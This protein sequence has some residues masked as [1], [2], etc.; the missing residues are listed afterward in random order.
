MNDFTDAGENKPNQTQPVVS[1]SNLFQKGLAI[2]I[3]NSP[4][5]P[6]QKLHR[7][8]PKISPKKP[9]FLKIRT[10]P[11]SHFANLHK[12]L[13]P[14]DAVNQ[15]QC[16]Q[17]STSTV[18]ILE[19]G[20]CVRHEKASRAAV[21]NLCNI[22]AQPAYELCSEILGQCLRALQQAVLRTSLWGRR[23][24]PTIEPFWRIL[25]WALH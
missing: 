15:R 22:Q 6:T 23:R 12:I 25:V 1:L 4:Q 2:S 18:T 3:S 20:R 11:V 8:P 7:Q 24:N 16:S 17:L 9:I 5:Q 13:M 10:I 21:L 19:Y 14:Y